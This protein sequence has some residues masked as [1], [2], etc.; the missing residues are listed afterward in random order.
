MLMTSKIRENKAETTDRES[1]AL[2][3]A[4]NA[5]RAEK[6]ARLRD[7][8]LARDAEAA[9]SK[10]SLKA[11]APRKRNKLVAKRPEIDA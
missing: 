4:Q 2:I 8:R 10:S 1:Y 3:S 5:A 9:A 6:T 7:L 11:I